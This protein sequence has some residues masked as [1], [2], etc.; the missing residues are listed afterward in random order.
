MWAGGSSTSKDTCSL[1]TTGFYSQGT[2]TPSSWATKRGDEK[3]TGSKNW[4][5]GNTNSGDGCNSSCSL[6]EANYQWSDGLLS[7]KDTCNLWSIGY[8]QQG[9]K[10]PNSCV[11]QWGDEKLVASE[12]WDD[13]NIS[14][15]DEWS[16]IYTIQS[17]YKWTGG[18]YSTKDSW[19]LWPAVTI[20]QGTKS[21]NTWTNPWGNGK[22]DVDESWDD[23]NWIVEMDAKVIAH[24]LRLTIH[25]LIV[26]LQQ[27]IYAQF[28]HFYFI[29]KEHRVR[30]HE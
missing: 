21:P 11:T 27:R 23:G 10:S 12:A 22:L 29:V 5:D 25:E 14:N 7:N 24:L 17:R 9:T 6:I 2:S 8:Y 15:G 26:F 19:S 20:Q 16:S 1:C 13:G 4:D 28:A 18:P 3:L 30:V